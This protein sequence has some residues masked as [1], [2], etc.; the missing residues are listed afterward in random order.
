MF[1]SVIK[2]NGI[3]N[4]CFD[5]ELTRMVNCVEKHIERQIRRNR[6]MMSLKLYVMCMSLE[7]IHLLRC[8][9]DLGCQHFK[10]NDIEEI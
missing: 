3:I 8:Y 9:F 2:W 7:I 4:S 6:K 1:V 10:Y 5:D